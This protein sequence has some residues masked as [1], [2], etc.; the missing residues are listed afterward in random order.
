MNKNFT[1]DLSITSRTHHRIRS[2]KAREDERRTISE[3]LADYLTSRFGTIWFLIVNVTIFVIWILINNKLFPNIKPFDPF[4]Y[5]F[6]T[7]SVSLEA[8][9]LSTFVLISQNRAAKVNDL[10]EEIDLQVDIIA[11][12]ELKKL[13]QLI[14]A[15][16]RKQG[17][18]I[19]EDE[20]LKELLKETDTYTIERKLEKQ[21]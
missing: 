10:R 20:V 18:K 12:Q 11:E 5:H 13:T 1:K 21:V 3:K 6:L 19:E 9:I 8:I 4:P 15:L 14:I 17:V 16:I 2:L 7:F